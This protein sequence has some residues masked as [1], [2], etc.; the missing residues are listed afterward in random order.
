MAI[1]GVI[2][3]VHANLEA[4]RR[5]LAFLDWESLDRVVCLGDIVG[6]NSDP[7]A[8]VDLLRARGIQSIAGNHDQMAVGLRPLGR[9]S[10]KVAFAT[11]RTV[12]ALGADARAFLRTLPLTRAY[13]DGLVLVHGSFDDCG[14]YLSSDTRLLQSAAAMRALHPSARICLYGHTHLPRLSLVGAATVQHRPHAPPLETPFDEAGGH[15][16]GDS[17]LTFI[18]PGAVDAARRDDA[19]AELAIIDTDRRTV[20]F[21]RVLYNKALVEAR[22]RARG[23]RMG[24]LSSLLSRL[25]RVWWRGRGFAARLARAIVPRA[26][27]ERRRAES[28]SSPPRNR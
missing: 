13:P 3:D 7:D 11:R 28:P 8:C 22:A 5:A 17:M 24:P 9:C 16:D 20:R 14:T 27:S 26:A 12:Q 4:L 2:S 21:E 18:N 23:Y 19:F 1:T 6:Y 10:D 25:R 15:G